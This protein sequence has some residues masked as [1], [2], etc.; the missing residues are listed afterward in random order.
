M[1]DGVV[2]KVLCHLL[3]VPPLAQ[4]HEP[5][6]CSVIVQED[7]VGLGLLDLLGESGEPHWDQLLA[8]CTLLSIGYTTGLHCVCPLIHLSVEGGIRCVLAGPIT[9]LI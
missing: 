5:M 2:A 4:E 3:L 9:V 6:R 7:E 8:H 1:E